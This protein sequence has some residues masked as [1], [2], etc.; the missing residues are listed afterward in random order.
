MRGLADKEEELLKELQKM[1]ADI[2]IISET[3]KKLKG[4]KDVPGSRSE[5]EISIEQQNHEESAWIN[6]MSFYKS[7]DEIT[8]PTMIADMKV[9]NNFLNEEEEKSL[10]EEI[11]PYMSKLRYEFDHWDNAIHG[12]RETERLKWNSKNLALLERVSKF[13]FPP[14]KPLLRLVH[15]LDLNEKGFIKPHIDSTRFCGDTIA[16]LSLLSDCVMKLVHNNKKDQVVDVLLRRRSLYIMKNTA[17]Y[18][19]THEILGADNSEFAGE[20]VPRGRRLS[21][22]CRCE[23]ENTPED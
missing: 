1:R 11:E 13:A 14:Y 17:R 9:F 8:K 22:I 18:D 15:V 19:F 23:P 20:K 6:Y 5:Y 10:Y 2:A 4:T 21:I 16:G 12:Y 3:K 7:Y